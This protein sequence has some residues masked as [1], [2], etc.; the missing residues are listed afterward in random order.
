[1]KFSSADDRF[2]ATHSPQAAAIVHLFESTLVICGVIFLIVVGLVAFC[3]WHFRARGVKEP[4]QTEGNR[5]LEVRRPAHAR[6]MTI[7]IE[8]GGTN[9]PAFASLLNPKELDILLAFLVSRA[10]TP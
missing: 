7:R 2:L 6:A 1:M 10:A 8:N 5:K 3:V 4:S 9:M